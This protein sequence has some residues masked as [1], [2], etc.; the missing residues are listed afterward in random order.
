MTIPVTLIKT[1]TRQSANA[2]LPTD[3]GTVES[4]TY[5]KNYVNA[6]QAFIDAGNLTQSSATSSDGLVTTVT[7]VCDNLTTYSNLDTALD[8]GT[9]AEYV[10]YTLTTGLTNTVIQSGISQPYTCTNSYTF[11][12]EGL[13]V[14]DMLVSALSNNTHGKL[15]NLIVNNTNI[16]SI[17]A[18]NN[19][20]DFN[21]GHWND[22]RLANDLHTA[23]VTKTVTYALV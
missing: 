1:F 21:S 3:A 13:L 18:Y 14:H 22:I 9:V 4:T 6:K 2:S 15:S 7:L 20:D 5:I 16:T 8:L 11:P 23:G 17:H 19:S 10:Q 12:S